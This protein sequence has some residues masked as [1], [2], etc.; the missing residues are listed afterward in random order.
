MSTREKYAAIEK[1]EEMTSAFGRYFHRLDLR[2]GS[3]GRDWSLSQCLLLQQLHKCGR[4]RMS[5]LARTFEVTLGNV[6]TMIDRLVREGLVS[7]HEDPADRRAVLVQLSSRGRSITS[8]IDKHKKQAMLA[9]IKKVSSSDRRT[10][11][12]ILGQLVAHINKERGK[13]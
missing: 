10:L 6:S 4:C 7:R 8:K 2:T 11:M 5:D 9:L 12:R 13:K 1:I 3:V